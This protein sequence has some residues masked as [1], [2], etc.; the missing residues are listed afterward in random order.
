MSSETKNRGIIIFLILLISIIGYLSYQN[1]RDYK[2]LKN[3]FIE[4]KKGLQE[5]LDKI[6]A[7]YDKIID[8]NVKL[9]SNLK[10]KKLMVL[11]LRDSLKNLQENNFA[12]I[13]NYR[14]R[15][16]SLEEENRALF[17][18]IDYLNTT[19]TALLNENTKVK[20]ELVEK[21]NLTSK[22]KKQN[23]QLNSYS[24]NLEKKISL[25]S[26]IQLSK[27]QVSAMKEKADEKYIET[28]R[29]KRTDAFK[30]TFTLKENK[31]AEEG[32]RNVYVSVF[33]PD[34]SI[35]VDK[36][37]ITLS[38][39]SKVPYSSSV[40]FNYENSEISL[41]SFIKVDRK[42]LVKGDYTFNIYSNGNLIET[43]SLSL[44]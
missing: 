12:L 20:E 16:L 4:E 27:F 39:G 9:E 17:L 28:T 26:A 38:D 36:G 2:I 6:I 19:N 43:K 44:R 15:I 30:V 23:T 32:K 14:N 10:E 29:Y 21:E 5:D 34:N 22:L 31:I 37:D 11:Q 24:K 7:D 1:V 8:K 18:K 3:A 13:K 33:G 42:V 35:V 25:A 41:F 40:N